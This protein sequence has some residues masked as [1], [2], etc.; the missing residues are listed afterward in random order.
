MRATCLKASRSFVGEHVG[1]IARDLT[2][3]SPAIQLV[4]EHHDLDPQLPCRHHDHQLRSLR[5]PRL[6]TFWLHPLLSIVLVLTPRS[7]YRCTRWQQQQQ[8]GLLLLVAGM[9]SNGNM[10]CVSTIPSNNWHIVH[11]NPS[12][13]CAKQCVP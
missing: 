9:Y 8:L 7:P 1:S 11:A 3:D 2:V 12:F 13:F 5:A 4:D 10:P 6:S